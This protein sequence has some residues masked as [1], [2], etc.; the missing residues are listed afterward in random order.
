MGGGEYDRS[1]RV[2]GRFRNRD[3]PPDRLL[4]S[5]EFQF[6]VNTKQP[7]PSPSPPRPVC[8]QARHRLS[9]AVGDIFEIRCKCCDN[10]SRDNHSLL[11]NNWSS[12]PMSARKGRPGRVAQ[13]RSRGLCSRIGRIALY[14]LPSSTV[15]NIIATYL[16]SWRNRNQIDTS[17]PH[18]R[19]APCVASHP[20]ERPVPGPQCIATVVAKGT[21][22]QFALYN[23][24]PIVRG[25]VVIPS[26]AVQLIFERLLTGEGNY[27]PITTATTSTPCPGVCR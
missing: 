10:W 12:M 25:H 26:K 21:R 5:R 27:P 2:C 7:S 22:S 6:A 13:R 9:T 18:D 23:L 1:G 15:I 24:S 3:T 19:T 8:S 14:K 4:A 16:F 20:L 11:N 17:L